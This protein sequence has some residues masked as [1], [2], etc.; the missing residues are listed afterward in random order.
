MTMVGN[1]SQTLS[2]IIGQVGGFSAPQ[3]RHFT[4]SG[5]P[6]TSSDPDNTL[7]ASALG[8]VYSRTDGPDS[9]HCFYVKTGP[10]S[11]AA[12]NGTWTNK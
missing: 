10:E 1:V 2:V 8:S 7:G 4:G 3:T 9:T 5:D 11:A 6:N 12:P